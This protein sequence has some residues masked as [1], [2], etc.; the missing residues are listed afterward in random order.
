MKKLL[1]ASALATL[2]AT[3]AQAGV[4][5]FTYGQPIQEERTEIYQAFNLDLFDSNLGTLTGTSIS[6]LTTG[7]TELWLTNNSEQNQ[8]VAAT[9]A[10]NLLFDTDNAA[11]GFIFSAYNP[12]SNPILQLNFAAFTGTAI[13]PGETI[14]SGVITDDDS[15]TFA[16]SDYASLLSLQQ[17]GGGTSFVSCASI[18]SLNLTGGGGNVGSEQESY[19]GCSVSVSYFYEPTSTPPIDPP[20]QVPEPTTLALL[21]LG[22]GITA[23]TTVAKRR[24][25]R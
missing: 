23:F 2:G 19:A 24:H 12:F 9:T 4:I 10:V 17:A 8:F 1:L 14:Y 5:S 6:A 7:N 22:L 11:L 3:Q 18:S 15:I 20:T 21:G 13:N 25:K 16:S